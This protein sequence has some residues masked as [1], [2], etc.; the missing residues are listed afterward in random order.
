MNFYSKD[1]GVLSMYFPYLRGRQFE[2]IALR[3]LL[4]ADKLGEKIIPI[5]EPVKPTSTLLKTLQMFSHKN[6]KI[7]VVSNPT[8]GDFV[9]K[10][11]TLKKEES[12]VA[13][14][15]HEFLN[16]DANVIKAFINTPEMAKKMKSRA[17]KNDFM[18]INPNRDCL[19]DFLDIYEESF[20]MYTLIPDDRAF[21]RIIPK[22]KVLFEDCFKKRIR[23]VDYLQKEDEF[24][25]DSHLF[26]QDEKFMG[27]SD[28]SVV[29]E[30]YN[31]SGFAPV[32][33]AIHLVYFDSDYNLRVHHF[34]SDSNEGIE[35]PAGK[36]GEA[37]EKLVFWCE[38]N[39]VTRTMG[40]NEFYSCLESG[41]YPG[42]GTVKKL[43][44]MHHIELM[45]KY[46]EEKK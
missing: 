25:S 22:T 46:L 37:L 14:E 30:E 26:Y 33:V 23:N 40:L 10:L 18:A 16:K 28:Y 12:A 2:L 31:E 3:E 44:I 35:D 15:L 34:V 32:A 42:L 4:E 13:I 45:S 7:A 39:H 36:F 29:G 17:D 21:K 9:K 5:I 43:S 1:M 11:N 19:D 20:P 8:V 24:F 41:K 27:F 6:R 38:E